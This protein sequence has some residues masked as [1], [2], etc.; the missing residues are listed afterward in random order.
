MVCGTLA[1]AARMESLPV[2]LPWP[3]PP[4]TSLY[5]IQRG[6]PDRLYTQTPTE[7]DGQQ[8]A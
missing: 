6:H 5:E 8:R 7:L 2:R 4:V 1:P 3:L